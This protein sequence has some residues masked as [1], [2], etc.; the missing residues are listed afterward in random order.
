MLNKSSSKNKGIGYPQPGLLFPQLYV[1]SCSSSLSLNVTASIRPSLN[2][3]SH[4][5][6]FQT[7]VSHSV[8]F[9]IY[10]LHTTLQNIKLSYLL[11]F[12]TICHKEYKA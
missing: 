9:A 11:T 4:V 7:A 6:S 12:L 2:N 5:A 8:S 3:L 1:L 10:S